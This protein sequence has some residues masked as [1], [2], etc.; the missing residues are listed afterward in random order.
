M[1]RIEVLH[2]LGFVHCDIKPD[3][4]LISSDKK[5]NTILL[6]DFGLSH[7]FTGSDGSHIDAP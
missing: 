4:I 2:N 6:V 7:K 3:N 1:T 5:D